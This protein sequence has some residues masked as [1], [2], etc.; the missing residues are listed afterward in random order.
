MRRCF[1]VL[2][3]VAAVLVSTPADA[4]PATGDERASVAML[5]RLSIRE[6]GVNAGIIPVGVTRAGHLDIGRSVRDV[7]RWRDG[8]VPGQDGSAVLAGHTWSEGPGVF[9]HLGRLREGDRV[10][11][12][13]NRFR[14]TRVRR[15]TDMSR[16]EVAALFSDRGSARLVLITCGDRNNLTGVYRKRII[17]NARMLPRR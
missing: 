12:G 16:S 4:R 9:D 14:V 7:Y 6:I 3:A 10:V 1:V 11:V 17:V 8:V 13:R 2:L 15:V 5:G